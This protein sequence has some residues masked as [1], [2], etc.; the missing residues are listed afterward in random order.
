MRAMIS[1]QR[2]LFDIPDDV[3]YLNCSYLGPTLASARRAG[4]AA[5]GRKS[6]PWK[7][8]A[9]DFFTEADEARA[10]FAALIGASPADIA[11]TPSAGFGVSTAAVNLPL[12]RGQ[13]VVLLEGEF[14]SNYYAWE[15]LARERGASLAVV[16]R[17]A[18][19]DWTEA[20]VG[21][22]GPDAGIV[23]CVACHW[24]DGSLVDL[25]RVG[26]R[27]RE[28]GAALVVDATQWVGAAPF[29][30]EEVQPDF[31]AVAAYKWLL[32]PYGTGFLYVAPK[33][34]GGRPLEEG[35]IP[36]EGSDDF[37]NLVRYRSEF[38]PGAVRFDVGERS[39]MIAL[40]M[41]N[42]SLRQ[43]LA[44]GVA[45]IAETLGSVTERIAERARDLGFEAAPASRRAPHI[46]G[47]RLAGDVPEDLAARLAA[48]RVYVS[49]RGPSVRL[50]PHLY[51][52]DD[53]LDR[54]FDALGR[55][56]ASAR[57]PRH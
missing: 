17:P 35:W 30:V 26:E 48:E 29:S 13:S 50:S 31:L 12:E 57:S 51:V 38:R 4:E 46:V 49:L 40:P 32:S 1:N 41:V 6:S 33:W 47:L 56:A 54:F 15:R 24:T 37:R 10:L 22:I 43:I 52:T 23:S 8:V 21:R 2:A 9:A 20:V 27:C 11:I 44:W 45:G 42:E 55:H 3:S 34:Q 16:P 14:P 36:R 19:G 5:V 18:D 25:V 7:I 39:N 28:V 53:D